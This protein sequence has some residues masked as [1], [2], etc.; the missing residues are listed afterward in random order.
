[1][2]LEEG[3]VNLDIEQA[4]SAAGELGRGLASLEAGRMDAAHEMSSSC[5][6]ALWLIIHNGPNLASTPRGDEWKEL[7]KAV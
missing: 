1:M 3:K 4:L 7:C 2:A 6:T 5:M